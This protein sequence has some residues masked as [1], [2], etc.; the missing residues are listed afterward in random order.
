MRV[1]F[2]LG[3]ALATLALPATSVADDIK[4]GPDKRIGGAFDV[5]VVTGENKGRTMCYV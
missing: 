4:S 3:L 5:K 1:T 2:G